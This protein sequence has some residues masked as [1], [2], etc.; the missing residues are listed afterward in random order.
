MGDVMP[1]Y[2]VEARG[3]LRARK[4]GDRRG[5]YS[6]IFDAASNRCALNTAALALDETFESFEDS[7]ILKYDQSR[8]FTQIGGTRKITAFQN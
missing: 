2:Q 4:S 6:W 1:Q 3:V 7:L 8:N 5:Y